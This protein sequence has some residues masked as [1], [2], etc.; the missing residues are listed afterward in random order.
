MNRIVPSF[1]PGLP[2]V[3]VPLAVLI[4]VSCGDLL[5]LLWSS[6]GPSKGLASLLSFESFVPL[7]DLTPLVRRL[8]LVDSVCRGYFWVKAS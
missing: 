2:C 4:A 1:R 5:S 8:L 3:G 6:L 7:A